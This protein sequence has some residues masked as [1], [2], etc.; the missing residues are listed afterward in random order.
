MPSKAGATSHKASI[1]P[2]YLPA[3]TKSM[4]AGAKKAA[5]SFLDD[6]G[7]LLAPAEILKRL[8]PVDWNP[9]GPTSSRNIK[10]FKALKPVYGLMVLLSQSPR[11][12][13]YLHALLCKQQGKS[14]SAKNVLLRAMLPASGV[15]E[16]RRTG[17]YS[18]ILL[19]VCGLW[20]Q[21]VSPGSVMTYV[22]KN[23]LTV[24][25]IFKAE[26][27]VRLAMRGKRNRPK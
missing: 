13:K 8:K 10:R 24:E 18:E 22:R 3:P 12:A 11:T 14:V 26:R 2:G 6:S 16:Q 17:L 1:V 27:P 19:T 25:K 15:R 21:K 20:R 7:N 4:V 5:A 9:S 23:Q